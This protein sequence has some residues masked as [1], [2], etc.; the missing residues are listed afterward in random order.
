MLRSAICFRQALL[1]SAISLIIWGNWALREL[2]TALIADSTTFFAGDFSDK[3]ISSSPSSFSWLI[4]L[5]MSDWCSKILF[6]QCASRKGGEK[7]ADH[8]NDAILLVLT[9]IVNNLI[10]CSLRFRNSNCFYARI[11]WYFAL[12]FSFSRKGICT[13]LFE[14]SKKN[15]NLIWDFSFRFYSPRQNVSMGD[16]ACWSG[17]AL[18]AWLLLINCCCIWTFGVILKANGL[19]FFSF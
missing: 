9:S 2:E 4:I 11:K 17:R 1:A 3:V 12:W 10:Y 18:H 8:F 7:Q 14:K 5:V 6:V 13:F 19:P 16:E 15:I